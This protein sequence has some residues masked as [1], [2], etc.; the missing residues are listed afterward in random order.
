MFLDEI[1]LLLRQLFKYQRKIDGCPDDDNEVIKMRNIS[2]AYGIL[3]SCI[4]KSR[5]ERFHEVIGQKCY[6]KV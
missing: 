1:D 5:K 4:S 6:E 3:L 2:N